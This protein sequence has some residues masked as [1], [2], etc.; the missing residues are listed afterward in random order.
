[1]RAHETDK[2]SAG[3]GAQA[4][5]TTPRATE[6][7]SA[8]PANAGR[9]TF[10]V[11]EFTLETTSG[12]ITGPAAYVRERLT[13]V[14]DEIKAGRNV[15]FNYGL[16]ASPNVETALLVAIQTDYAAWHGRRQFIAQF[17][18]DEVGS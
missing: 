3:L 2:T 4:S 8:G 11:G 6:A 17:A 7:R 10:S 13:E 18:I 15:C 12:Q 1:M 9:T 16:S 5:S 14:L